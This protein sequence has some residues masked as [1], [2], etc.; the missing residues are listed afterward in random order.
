M[1]YWVPISTIRKHTTRGSNDWDESELIDLTTLQVITK[2][3]TYVV[4]HLSLHNMH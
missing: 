2:K 3:L 1:S 4:V